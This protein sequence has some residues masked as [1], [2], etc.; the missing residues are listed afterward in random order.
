MNT[1]PCDINSVEKGVHLMQN[2]RLEGQLSLDLGGVV[3]KVSV[4]LPE[5]R[6]FDGL[7][8]VR[9]KEIRQLCTMIVE[10]PPRPRRIQSRDDGQSFQIECE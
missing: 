4:H 2:G 8:S 9:W 7:R 6:Q 1:H 10:F 5:P 3:G